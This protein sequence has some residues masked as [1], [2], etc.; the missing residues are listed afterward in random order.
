M[1]HFSLEFFLIAA[2]AVVFAGISKGGFGSG[3][4]FVSAAILTL[5]IEPGEA[6]AIM[7]PLL[8]LIDLVTLRPYWGVWSFADAKVLILGGIPG[9]ALGSLLFQVVDADIFRLL[10]GA[11]S[12][13][14]VLWSI[15]PT[16]VSAGDHKP[17]CPDWIGVLL[18]SV[19]GFTSFVAHAGG[20]PA[21]IFLLSRQ[22]RKTQY[23]ATTVLVFWV[24]N[25]VKFFCY[26][27]LGMMSLDSGLAA[28]LLAPFAVVG[29]YLGV[30]A[31]R[32][33]PEKLF[34]RL[35]FVLLSITGIKLIYDG[36]C[37][38]IQGGT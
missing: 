8:M 33:I 1:Q 11:V 23:Q 15:L 10:I 35:A 18:G 27:W 9:V 12:L 14:F 5:V 36:L 4:A 6:L 29:A 34:F 13:V 17:Y 26:S 30:Y 3:V 20:P 19:A 21:A 37:G 38:L 25:I 7:L 24:L 28:V 32:L 31:H 2:P 16:R 22:I